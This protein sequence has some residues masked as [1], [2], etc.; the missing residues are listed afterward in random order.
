MK[1]QLLQIAYL[2][3]SLFSLTQL[4]AQVLNQDKEGYSTLVF[5]GGNIS[6]DLAN[7]LATFSY[8]DFSSESKQINDSIRRLGF[9]GL[10]LQGKE[11]EG[12][13]SL[14]SG[15]KVA[16]S[17]IGNILLGSRWIKSKKRSLTNSIE[18]KRNLLRLRYTAIEKHVIIKRNTAEAL[19]TKI[20]AFE[21][22]EF[23]LLA[24]EGIKIYSAIDPDTLMNR[25]SLF[26]ISIEAQKQKIPANY[27]EAPIWDTISL[28]TTLFDEEYLD[29]LRSRKKILSQLENIKALE[30][31]TDVTSLFF[32]G[33]FSAS[34]FKLDE[35]S[36]AVT[37]DERFKEKNF[38][39]WNT[40]VGWN[41]QRNFFNYFG[42]T[43]RLQYS[44]NLDDLEAQEFSFTQVDTN[45]P[46]SQLSTTEKVNALS[47]EFD[48]FFRHSLNFDYVRTLKIG[49]NGVSSQNSNL[50]LVVNPYLRHNIYQDSRKLK[51]NTVAGFGLH[52][53][54]S[55]KQKLMGGIFIQ[56]NDLF[57]VHAG[58]DNALGKR[59]SIGLI[60]KVGFSGF[61]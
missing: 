7:N 49:E 23:K 21:S 55:E 27:K 8:A 38:T 17:G 24:K 10:E 6:L 56:T 30:I 41:L 54:N 11:K 29:T 52:A 45:I 13:L 47:G 39:G 32:R 9:W 60:A 14:F 5:P 59:I 3:L 46:N 4:Q 51:N 61:E 53:F 22:S 42:V 37:I 57:G 19:L 50:F 28:F 16:V 26:E 33:G 34:S 1:N 58:D 31:G 2:I 48:E 43:Y 36:S 44:N 20:Y 40:E 35:N 12:I 18:K 25:L 15:G